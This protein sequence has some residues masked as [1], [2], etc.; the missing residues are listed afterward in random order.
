MAG[1]SEIWCL[2][3]TSTSLV[4][5]GARVYRCLRYYGVKIPNDPRVGVPPQAVGWL[6][7]ELGAEVEAGLRATMPMC[8]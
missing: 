8:C 2:G 7:R 4:T 5:T 6:M 1:S 3:V